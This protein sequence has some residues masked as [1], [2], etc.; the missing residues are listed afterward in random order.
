MKANT[1]TIFSMI[2]IALMLCAAPVLGQDT[3]TAEMKAKLE[4]LVDKYITSCEAKSAL[5]RSNSENIRRSATLACLKA[6]YCRHH[7]QQLVDELVKQNIEPKPYKVQRFLS[8]KF[9]DAVPDHNL[10]AR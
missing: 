5:L 7:R 3:M 10:A 4:A 1:A 2:V 8:E 6:T 9:L